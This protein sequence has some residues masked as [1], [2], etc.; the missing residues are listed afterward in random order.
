M[1][2]KSKIIGILAIISIFAI[3]SIAVISIKHDTPAMASDIASVGSK[4]PDFIL[5]DLDGKKVRLSDH[6]GQ[7]VLLNFWAT[8]CPPCRAEMPSMENLNEKMKGKD[9]KILA[10]SIDTSS[11]ERVSD[12][13]ERKGYTFD[14]LYDPGQTVARN[15]LV[16]GIPTTY[17][18]DKKGIIVE[19]SVGAE[20]WDTEERIEQMHELLGTKKEQ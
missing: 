18:I 5:K 1:K 2:N 12:F 13:I 17:I 3:L 10:V 8:W 15:Y 4:A 11:S 7:I 9:F 14:I 20:M 6:E 16:M 19:K